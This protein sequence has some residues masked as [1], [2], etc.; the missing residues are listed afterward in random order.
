MDPLEVLD[1]PEVLSFVFHPR[2]AFSRGRGGEVVLFEVEDGVRIGCKFWGEGRENATILYFHG[3]GEIVTDYD[4]I[5]P[6]YLR[7]GLNLL[8]PDYRGYGLSDGRP[9]LRAMLDDA[10]RLF[11][12]ATEWLKQR[13]FHG[14]L[15]VMGRSL[16][17]LSAVE[18][19][20]SYREEFRG[21]IVESGSATNFRNLLDSFGLIPWDHP[22]WEEGRGF[23]NKEKIRRVEVPTLIIHAERDS[24][25]PLS[26]AEELYRNAGAA[27]KRLVVIPGADH[28]DLMFV[29]KERYFGSIEDFVK[30]V[31][32]KG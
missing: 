1:V 14:P 13:G 6:E 8:V 5:A 2:R 27:D 7:R 25:I 26:E 23:F 17:S 9:T 22:I 21:L 12:H 11:R 29:D 18:L 15:F 16:G 20:S 10:H 19:A 32:G 4:D 28:N 24:L 30:E 3:N 31:W